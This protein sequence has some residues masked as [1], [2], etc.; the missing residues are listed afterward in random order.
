AMAWFWRVWLATIVF[1]FPI[2]HTIALRNLLLLVG[3]LLLLATLRQAPRPRFPQALKAAAWALV[4]TT[5][6]LV[7]H[8]LTVAPAPTLALD[9]LRGDWIVPLLTGV[10]AAYAAARAGPRQALLAVI[11]ALLAHM[12]WVL[13]W[14]LWHRLEAGPTWAWIAG[15]V[16][17]AER[18]YQS[19]LN[20]FLFAILL[21]ERF[22]VLSIGRSAALLPSWL[23]WTALVVSL[24]ADNVLQTRNGTLVSA[25]LLLMATLWISRRKPRFI[26]LL[27]AVAM[28]GAASFAVDSRWRGLQESLVIGWQ[29]PSLFWMNQDPGIR[30]S[31]PSGADLE[32]SAYVRAAWARQA[33][34]ALR[35][36]PLGS[37]FGRDGFGRV[38]AEKYGYQGM[39]S[40]HSGW[41]DFALGAGLPGLALLLLAAGLAMR[42]G[43]RQFRQDDDAVG[44]MLGF[45]VGGYLLRCLLD[46]HLSGWRLGLFAFISG[47]L[48]AA[49]KTSRPSAGTTHS[50]PSLP[51]KE[52][53]S[54]PLREA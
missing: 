18:D 9:N 31:T 20:G 36:Q 1:V 38:V 45:F 34:L 35:E 44:L 6:W 15:R 41:L 29:S 49:M 40:S 4:A 3:V 23:A 39:V 25:T 14:A 26:V 32:E 51:E 50:T 19:T 16:P 13:G 30:P 22:A 54:A 27:L 24:A 8:S 47:A 48:V 46:G 28:L 17:F 7:L 2:P 43:W 52:R 53:A 42:G 21:A 11:A 12:L 5:A 37:G 33:M 10:L